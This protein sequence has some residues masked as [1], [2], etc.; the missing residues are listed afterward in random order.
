MTRR[1]MP[2]VMIVTSLML[3]AC[4][5]NNNDKLNNMVEEACDNMHAAWNRG[6]H[7]AV[8][9]VMPRLRERAATY[10]YSAGEVGKAFESQCTMPG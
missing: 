8:E 1:I 7:E 2:L 5:N 6:N 3:P 9:R 10:G 4:E